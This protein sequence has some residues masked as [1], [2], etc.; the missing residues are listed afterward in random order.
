MRDTTARFTIIVQLLRA[1]T[2]ASAIVVS[3][4]ARA[5]PDD[6][7]ETPTEPRVSTPLG[8]DGGRDC[9]DV[10]VSTAGG[11]PGGDDPGNAAD[12]ADAADPSRRVLKLS[13]LNPNKHTARDV[14]LA[15]AEAACRSLQSVSTFYLVDEQG[16]VFGAWIDRLSGRPLLPPLS[17]TAS[18]SSS[19][20]GP[21]HDRALERIARRGTMLAEPK[22]QMALAKAGTV[23]GA[24]VFQQLPH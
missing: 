19:S 2:E 4:L 13:R 3:E 23:S 14:Q 21:C 7:D 20:A 6:A 18:A 16:A 15:A 5:Q 10:A 22:E 11:V 24:V 9:A 8:S 17:V 12:A 1:D